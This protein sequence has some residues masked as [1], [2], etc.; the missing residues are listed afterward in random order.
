MSITVTFACNIRAISIS[1]RPRYQQLTKQLQSSVRQR[2]EM[3]DG[4]KVRIDG[5]T[6]SLTETAEWMSFERLCC[7]FLTLQLEASGKE[8]DWFLS[9]KGPAGVKAFLDAELPLE[10]SE[11]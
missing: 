10:R 3:P 6:L 7:P 5:S 2:R 1:E 8:Q 9:L 4:Y 11:G